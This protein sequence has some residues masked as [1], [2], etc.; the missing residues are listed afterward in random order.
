MAP[1]L[2]KFNDLIIVSFDAFDKASN[3]HKIKLTHIKPD[4][5]VDPLP[6]ITSQYFFRC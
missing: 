2:V 3:R 4:V 1:E 5:M 6:M